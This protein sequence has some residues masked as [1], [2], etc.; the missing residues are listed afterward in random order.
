MARNTIQKLHDD[1]ADRFPDVGLEL[2]PADDER[3]AWWL[4]LRRPGVE[5][6]VSIEWRTDRGFG[7][8]VP[9]EGDFGSG[10]DE[11]YPNAKAAFD[12]VVSLVLSGGRTTPPEAVRLADLRRS[13]GLSQVELADRVGVGQGNISRIENRGDVL[14]STLARIVASLGG[15]L[16]LKARFPDGVEREVTV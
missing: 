16:V 5:D 8:S 11:V 6:P 13:R 1:L 14:V 4:F 9:E 2:D 7:V 12:R 10:P 3:G 15:E